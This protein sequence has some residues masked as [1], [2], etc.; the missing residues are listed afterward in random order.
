MTNSL[1]SIVEDVNAMPHQG[2]AANQAYDSPTVTFQTFLSRM[3][4]R[5]H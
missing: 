5:F 2:V 4:L 1:E 3:G